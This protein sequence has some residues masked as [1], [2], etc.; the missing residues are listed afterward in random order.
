MCMRVL[1]ATGEPAISWA[2]RSLAIRIAVC[3]ADGSRR[4][5]RKL[6]TVNSAQA[7]S[8]PPSH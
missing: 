1:R 3:M 8:I 4:R 2:L 6:S 5:A 7:G